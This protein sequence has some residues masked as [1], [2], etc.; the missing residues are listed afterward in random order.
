MVEASEVAEGSEAAEGLEAVEGSE[1]AEG[2]R[3]HWILTRDT[4][5]EQVVLVT[6]A[7]QS[8]T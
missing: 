7:M 6:R 2:C 1:A 3:Q 8:W 5:R 4:S